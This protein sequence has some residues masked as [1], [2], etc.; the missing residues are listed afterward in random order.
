[1]ERGIDH[2]V[3]CVHDLDAARACYARLGFSL[4][5][6]ALHPFGT[7]NSLIQLHGNFIEILAVADAGAIAA[8]EPGHFSFAHHNKT[9]L[10]VGEG[11]SMLVFEGHDARADQ[12]E[13]RLKRLD[14]YEPFDFSRTARLPDGEEVTV[15]FSLAFVT[16]AEMPRAA[17]FT[18][19]QHAP[20][21]FWKP[22]YQVHGNT[23]R[24]VRAVVM[25]AAEPRRYAEF[26]AALQGTG[27]VRETAAGLQVAT[28]RGEIRVVTPEAYCAYYG[29]TARPDLESGPRFRAMVVEV[30]E[31]DAAK[32]CLEDAGITARPTSEGVC[33][34]AFGVDI[35]F[36]GP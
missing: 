31:M 36:A 17:F 4:T 22:E 32:R 33:V 25:V 18:C 3:V 20:Q 9:F 6:L 8:P 27:S 13:F 11:G 30:A 2:L 15:G 29:A 24:V 10:E 7:A 5:P 35:E 12:A 19:Q 1:M 23:A 14:T 34:H 28:A 26:F 21:H 16:H